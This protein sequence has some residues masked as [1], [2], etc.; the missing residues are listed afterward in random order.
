MYNVRVRNE[1]GVASRHETADPGW[2]ESAST[3][4]GA[5][6]AGTVLAVAGVPLPTLN[7]EQA[8]LF[9]IVRVS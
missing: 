7:P 3:S 4:G 5:V 9:D 8:M 2:V 1:I 6:L